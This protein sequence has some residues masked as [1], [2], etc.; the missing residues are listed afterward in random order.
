MREE[1]AM[2]P[3]QRPRAQRDLANDPGPVP[4]GA[5]DS[6]KKIVKEKFFSPMF[7]LTVISGLLLVRSRRKK[8]GRRGRNEA[9]PVKQVRFLKICRKK[10]W[11]Q[12]AQRGH[13]N[14]TGLATTGV[15]V[16]EK[17]I[18]KENFSIPLFYIN[19][20]ISAFIGQIW[21][22]KIWAYRAQRDLS[23]GLEPV[24]VRSGRKK[25]GRIGI[26]ESFPTA[27][28]RSDLDENNMGV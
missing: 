17:K 13:S 6:E 3:F 25:Y 12:R 14:D 2:R 4:T 21:T 1:G 11:A 10:I 22:N 28:G 18:V 15:I 24:H 26:K 16:T 23:N 7:N 8:Y 20:Y 27:P 19:R 9:F 5:T